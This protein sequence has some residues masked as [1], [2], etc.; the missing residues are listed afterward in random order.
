MKKEKIYQKH[1]LKIAYLKAKETNNYRIGDNKN[2]SNNNIYASCI[3]TFTNLLTLVF[4][5]FI[6]IFSSLLTSSLTTSITTFTSL[7][8]PNSPTSGLPILIATFFGL[9]ILSFNTLSSI[10][11]TGTF[12]SI[13]YF[14]FFFYPP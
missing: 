9:L 10:T 6:T 5:V 8:P 13:C 3:T 12:I 14:F 1:L 7:P 2:V 4:S 11:S